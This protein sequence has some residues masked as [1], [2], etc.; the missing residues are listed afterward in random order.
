MA[1]T[2]ETGNAKNVANFQELISYVTGYGPTYNPA[3]AAIT[4][5]ALNAKEAAAA[6]SLTA[7]NTALAVHTTAVNAR[8]IAFEAFEPILA[9]IASAAVAAGL[10]PE[11]IEDIRSIIRKL[12]G[13]RSGP[14]P[15]TIPDDP[16]TPEDESSTSHSVSQMSYDSRIENFEKLIELLTAQPLYAP[17]EADLTIAALNTRLTN[18]RAEN[19]AVVNAYTPLS[20]SR[21]E[22]NVLLYDETKGLVALAQAAKNYVKSIFG[23]SSPQW[24]QISALKFTRPT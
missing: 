11:V 15:P 23:A 16:A 13:S 21:I 12:R 17:N 4:V 8:E 6:T 22:R 9:R 20:N 14:K 5:A 1:S 3:N 18:M 2:S 24:D 7:V 10:S 19:L